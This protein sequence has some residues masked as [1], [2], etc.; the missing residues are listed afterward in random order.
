VFLLCAWKRERR[1]RLASLNFQSESQDSKFRVSF[2]RSSSGNS[3]CFDLASIF[4]LINLMYIF[5]IA[6]FVSF[7]ALL[8]IRV[9][10]FV[11]SCWILGFFVFLYLGW[12]ILCLHGLFCV[13]YCTES[14]KDLFFIGYGKGIFLCARVICECG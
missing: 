4:H 5:L 11:F 2:F 10:R 13:N 8:R 3:A 6:W 12:T 1:I 9:F 14:R 7:W